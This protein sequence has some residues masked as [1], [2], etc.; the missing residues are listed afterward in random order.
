[1]G[2]GEVPVWLSIV[3]AF[4]GLASPLVLAAMARDRSLLSMIAD[5]KSQ[6]AGMITD[7]KD[8]IMTTL[9][10]TTDPIHDRINRVRDEY[11]REDHL[12]AHLLRFEKRFDEI[13]AEQR[14]SAA[15]TNDGFR[16]IHRLLRN[17]PHSDES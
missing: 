5:V 14:R 7:A 3:L 6:T 17:G 11:V 16:E 13:S 9:K 10:A 4:A 2:N 12:N 1:M 8:D 15:Q